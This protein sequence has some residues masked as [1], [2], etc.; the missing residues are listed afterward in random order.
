LSGLDDHAALAVAAL[1]DLF[2]D[3]SLLKRVQV[4][5]W[6][7]LSSL[8]RPQRREAFDCHDLPVTDLRKSRHARP[9]R[10]TVE[11]HRAGATLVQ[12]AT[13][14]RPATPGH[15]AGRTATV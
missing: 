3:P 7:W 4:P 9:R 14:A 2:I 11:E 1:R 6:P 15:S 13:R 5:V 12:P 10:L 8:S